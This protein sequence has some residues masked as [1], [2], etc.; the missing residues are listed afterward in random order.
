MTVADEWMTDV[1]AAS[2]DPW[3]ALGFSAARDVLIGEACVTKPS[4]RR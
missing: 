1:V 2:H 3:N 4:S